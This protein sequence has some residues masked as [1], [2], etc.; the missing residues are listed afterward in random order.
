MS[1]IEIK[2][3]KDKKIKYIEFDDYLYEN[4]SGFFIIKNQYIIYYKNNIYIL[5]GIINNINKSKLSVLTIYIQI[6]MVFLF[7]I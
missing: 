6:Q 2:K 5:Y 4:N 7:L 3:S 1:I